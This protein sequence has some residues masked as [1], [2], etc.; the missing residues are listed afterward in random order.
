MLRNSFRSI[1]HF[2]CFQW[3]SILVL[4]RNNTNTT[5]NEAKIKREKHMDRVKKIL[6]KDG[7]QKKMKRKLEAELRVNELTDK[8]Q[9]SAEKKDKNEPSKRLQF[10]ELP[11]DTQIYD[12]IKKHSLYKSKEPPKVRETVNSFVDGVSNWIIIIIVRVCQIT[13][14]YL[15][16][17]FNRF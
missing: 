14:K 5:G 13:I 4:K 7:L 1:T 6:R 16:I 9:S 12:Y 2:S 10:K 3:E 8:I 11:Y 15:D 17:F